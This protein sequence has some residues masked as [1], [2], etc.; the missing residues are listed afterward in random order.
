MPEKT[1]LGVIHLSTGI[2]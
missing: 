2:F 1:S